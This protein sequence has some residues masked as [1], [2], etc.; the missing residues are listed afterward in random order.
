MIEVLKLIGSA[1]VAASATLL[2]LYLKRKWEKQDKSDEKKEAAENKI[3]KMAA[4]LNSLGDKVDSLSKE[5]IKEIIDIRR[6]DTALESGLRELLYDRIK[7]LCKTYI[8]EGRIGEEDYNSLQRMWLVYHENLN[9]NGYL[10]SIMAEVEDL[11]KI[12]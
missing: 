5:F 12:K 11:E 6:E 1:L 4:E 10:D 9:G 8:S 2:S 3:D 7:L